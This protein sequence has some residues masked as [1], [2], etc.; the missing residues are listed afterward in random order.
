MEVNGSQLHK[1]VEEALNTLFAEAPTLD[2]LLFTTDL[3]AL[4]GLKYAIKYGLD[5]PN[6]VEIMAVD[7]ASYYDIFPNE[8]S[9]YRQPLEKMVR[10]AVDFLMKRIGDPDLEPISEVVRGEI[11]NTSF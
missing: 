1:E 7:E 5:V 10:I 9:Y 2:A 4:Y 3:V 11:R 6:K 8:I